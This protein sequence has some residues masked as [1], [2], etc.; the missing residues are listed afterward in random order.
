MNATFYGCFQQKSLCVV[1]GVCI[2]LMLIKTTIKIKIKIAT[3]PVPN[4][5]I[6]PPNKMGRT[7]IPFIFFPHEQML[8]NRRR[9]KKAVDYRSNPVKKNNSLKCCVRG[10]QIIQ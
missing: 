10:K 2:L 1:G 6:N 4:C 8:P 9:K 3:C 7:G 5:T